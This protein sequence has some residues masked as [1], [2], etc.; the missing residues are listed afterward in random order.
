MIRKLLGIC[1]TLVP[2]VLMNAN[3]SLAD[4]GS[5]RFSDIS[6]VKS[7]IT[8]LGL[9]YYD[10][11]LI[12]DKNYDKTDV[13]SLSE[14]YID[15]GNTKQIVNYVYVYNPF[16]LKDDVKS[17]SLKYNNSII[18]QDVLS[19]TRDVLSNIVKYKVDFKM[20]TYSDLE[21]RYEISSFRLLTN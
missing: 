12:S 7:D 13:I 5:Y 9:N 18:T 4:T 19:S 20:P 6:T 2:L 14:S 1:I 21:R 16:A 8:Q 11:K 3:V 15:S 10:Y 17:F